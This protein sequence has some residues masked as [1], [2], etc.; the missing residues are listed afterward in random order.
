MSARPFAS[1][2]PPAPRIVAANFKPLARNSLVGFCALTLIDIGLVIE[3][4][5]VHRKNE[6]RWIGMPARPVLTKDRQ[7]EVDP[8]TGKIRYASIPNFTDASSRRKF[9]DAAV[10]AV[11]A[12]LA[13]ARS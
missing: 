12:L 10:A 7:L 8:A 13:E 6:E 2:A 9:Q 3:D 5:T 1:G 4:V 11:R